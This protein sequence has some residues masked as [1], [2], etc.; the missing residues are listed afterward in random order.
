MLQYQMSAASQRCKAPGA[1]GKAKAL[2]LM[3]VAA[4]LV[5]GWL[6]V[7]SVKMLRA[8]GAG[9]TSLGQGFD[10]PGP[11]QVLDSE[12]SVVLAADPHTSPPSH[13]SLAQAHSQPDK[14]PG[15]QTGGA[16]ALVFTHCR[17]TV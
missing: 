3:A 13:S 11:S 14:Y 9:A 4:L 8:Q 16:G 1:R 12:P 5:K 15:N 6:Q 7:P 10:Q 2:C 17:A